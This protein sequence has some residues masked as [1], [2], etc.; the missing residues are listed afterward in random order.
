MWNSGA[1]VGGE[2]LVGGRRRTVAGAVTMDQTVSYTH[3]DV[4]KR[5]GQGLKACHAGR[6]D[7]AGG[8]DRPGGGQAD[9]KTSEQPGTDVDDHAVYGRDRHTG[10]PA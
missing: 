2:V 8:G 7:V 4:Y 9:P 5:Q 10:V 6:G 3:L 1:P